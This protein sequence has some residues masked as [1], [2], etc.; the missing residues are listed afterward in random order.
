MNGVIQGPCL[1]E[2]EVLAFAKGRGDR[3]RTETHLDGCSLCRTLVGEAARQVPSG[4]TLVSGR[5]GAPE[6]PLER[7]TRLGRYWLLA[8]LG[9]GG[10]GVV[11][12]AY[13]P[14]LDRKVAIKL[15]RTLGW[16]AKAT[17]ALR[18][19]LVREGQAMARL[20]HPAVLPV[21]DI[22]EDGGR[23][24]VAMELAEGGTVRDWLQAGPR[25]PRQIVDLFCA[26]GRGLVAAH[27]AGLVHRDFK[28]DNVL[29]GRDGQPRVSDFGLARLAD[30]AN[31]PHET[32]DARRSLPAGE[33]L[34]SPLTSTD[35]LVGTPGYMAPEQIRS[36][37]ASAAS[38]QFS[39]CT[40]LWEALFGQRPF[41]AATVG[42]LVERAEAAQVRAAP[43]RKAPAHVRRVL[44]RGL[45]ADPALRRPSMDALLAALSRN[46]VRRALLPALVVLP[47]LL[48]AASAAL[49]QRATRAQQRLCHQGEQRLEGVWD[50]GLRRG[51]RAAFART[52]L[53]FAADSAAGVERGLDAYAR[54]WSAMY[55]EACEATHVRGE[56]SEELL[57]LRMHCLDQRRRELKELASLFSQADAKLVRSGAR[58]VLALTSVDSCADLRQL[59]G[60]PP[61]P[62]DPAGRLAHEEL[63]ASLARA[64]ALILAG[65]FKDAEEAAL[66]LRD[67]ALA[68][69]APRISARALLIAGRARGLQNDPKGAELLLHESAQLALAQGMPGTLADSLS[70]LAHATGYL[71]GRIEEGLRWNAYARAAAT[72]LPDAYGQ[73]ARAL[74]TEGGLRLRLG[75]YEAARAPLDEAERLCARQDHEWSDT[76]LL[77]QETLAAVL[78]STGPTSEAVRRQRVVAEQYAKLFGPRHPFTLR[79]RMNL[80]VQLYGDE[81]PHEALLVFEQWLPDMISVLGHDHLEVAEARM[82][83]GN[84]LSALDRHDE[85]LAQDRQAYSSL[86]RTQGEESNRAALALA[87]V[88][89]QLLELGKD[90]EAAEAL[91]RALDGLIAVK[92]DPQEITETRLLLGRALWRTRRAEAEKLVTSSR[93][94]VAEWQRKFPSVPYYRRLLSKTDA[95]LAEQQGRALHKSKQ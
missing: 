30:A 24:F 3:A 19:R 59:R 2:D 42:E 73:L 57:D 93:T 43:G 47:V 15:L 26:A 12:S 46:P 52:G 87:G 74:Q 55:V 36:G 64:Q 23:L 90:P 31:D 33:G 9:A 76:C 69:G 54:S 85:A 40:S 29:I 80:G 8:P 61:L 11:Y 82:N 58:P 13:D 91:R 28:P 78:M 34:A 5:A 18:A 92:A 86:R 65:R 84:V 62:K 10:M 27:A 17:E 6:R 70:W 20:S 1:S 22:G 39:F 79:A 50:E 60:E 41:D 4:T 48:G 53:A 83:L 7:G 71:S 94:E 49:V 56:Q 51:L 25:T 68:K 89:E 21:H 63:E 37:Q 95:W 88:G 16:D 44:L 75:Q 45:R 38:D 32:L 72:Q 81:R 14:Q 35:S 77:V 66:P 67:K